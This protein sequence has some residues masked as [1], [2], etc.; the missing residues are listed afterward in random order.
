[1]KKVSETLTWE[2]CNWLP[3][4]SR[5]GDNRLAICWKRVCC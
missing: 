1:M 3:A 2:T 4:Y 5:F